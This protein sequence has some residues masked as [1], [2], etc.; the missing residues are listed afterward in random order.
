MGLID[1]N[2]FLN[3]F[4]KKVDSSLYFLIFQKLNLM[5]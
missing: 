4:Y 2:Y 3:Y 5:D 1:E